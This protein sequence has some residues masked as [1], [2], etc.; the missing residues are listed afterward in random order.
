MAFWNRE[1]SKKGSGEKGESTQS[2]GSTGPVG[3]AQGSR[4][5]IIQS[6]RITEKTSAASAGG[7][8]VF[9]I[10]Q[11]ANKHE[12]KRAVEARYGVDVVRVNITRTPAKERR[13][14]RQIGWKKGIKKATVVLKEGQKIEIA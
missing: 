6:P 1:Q 2:A 7:M 3:F 13:R 10:G 14:G 4:S 5:G 8:Y 9:N 11:D 12:V